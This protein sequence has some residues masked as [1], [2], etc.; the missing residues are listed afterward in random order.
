MILSNP[1]G[2]SLSSSCSSRPGCQSWEGWAQHLPLGAPSA[3]T[4]SGGTRNCCLKWNTI[5]L[6]CWAEGVVK[7]LSSEV[8]RLLVIN[9]DVCA[10]RLFG[11]AKCRWAFPDRQQWP[12]PEAEQPP[13]KSSF[14]GKNVKA[15]L[16]RN[17]R[18]SIH[19]NL[20]ILPR[21]NMLRET[22]NSKKSFITPRPKSCD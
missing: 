14:P 11:R 4:R 13:V 8:L 3:G 20:K 16:H 19:F 21:V 5:S 7:K 1:R 18:H 15:Y 2:L 6:C 10:Y 12:P 22:C 9:C 17:L